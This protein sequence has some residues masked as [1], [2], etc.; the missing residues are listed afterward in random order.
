MIV[1]RFILYIRD[2][3]KHEIYPFSVINSLH[4][5]R[6]IAYDNNKINKYQQ[7]KI[8]YLLN[9]ISKYVSF[10][11]DI[12]FSVKEI[13]NNIAK[14]SIFQYI[15]VVLK[16][17]IKLKGD[18]FKSSIKGSYITGSTSGSSGMPLTV[19]IGKKAIHNRFVSRLFFMNLWNVR[20]WDRN[21]LIGGSR[22]SKTNS[23][24]H[25]I[26]ECM[27]GRY[28]INVFD[29]N[30]SN[31]FSIVDEI[32]KLK[33]IYI[34]GFKSGI[35]E[36]ALLIRNSN[37]KLKINSLKIVIVTS[38]VLYEKERKIIESVF[39]A[40]V[41]NEFGAV[42]AGLFAFECPMGH[43][44]INEFA[45]YIEV[46]EEN[47]MYVTEFDN[48]TM[49]LV[50]YKNLDRI[51][52]SNEN[53]KCGLK[54]RVIDNI[55]G[56]VADQIM[57]TNGEVLNF[58]FFYYLVDKID[59]KGEV[60]IQYRVEQNGFNFN[61]YLIKNFGWDDKFIIYIEN[62]MKN[63]IGDEIKVTFIFVDSINREKSGK[64]RDFVRIK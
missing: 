49:P 18:L 61:F 35:Y 7:Y 52:I 15:P 56:R 22:V 27:R 29:I 8:I 3:F 9:Y 17:D 6:S 48:L 51:I 36:L 10:Y 63:Y 20:I 2:V 40:K 37:V 24:I 64:L 34:R 13:E 42:E 16:R 32:N 31:I 45:D 25:N 38:E 57:K 44:H 28:Q 19:R 62:E 14:K 33:P 12:C 50:N 47:N 58:S 30:D 11:R 21:V 46:D 54:F 60:I 1:F 5:M 41:V 39:N 26:I 23:L 43:M 55:E 4:K 59:P 53:C